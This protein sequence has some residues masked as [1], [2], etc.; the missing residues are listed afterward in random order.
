MIEN[1]AAYFLQKSFGWANIYYE[2]ILIKSID[3]FYT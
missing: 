1:L 2:N 3:I